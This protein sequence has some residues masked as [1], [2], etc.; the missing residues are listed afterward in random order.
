MFFHVN[1]AACA[2]P[3]VD[4]CARSS[5]SNANRRIAL[6]VADTSRGGTRRSAFPTTSAIEVAPVL[7]VGQPHAMASTGP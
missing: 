3:A 6:A 4:S 5:G 2:R 7:I 1:R